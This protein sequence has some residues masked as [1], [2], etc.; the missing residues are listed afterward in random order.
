MC[1]SRLLGWVWWAWAPFPIIVRY[2]IRMME[3]ETLYAV[4]ALRSL[5]VYDGMVRILEYE[6]NWAESGG[7]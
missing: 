5:D 3:Y 4:L 1:D 6:T 2:D 7:M